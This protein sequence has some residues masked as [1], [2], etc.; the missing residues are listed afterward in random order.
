MRQLPYMHIKVIEHLIRLTINYQE[1]L[2]AVMPKVNLIL[3]EQPL[4]C[5][6]WIRSIAPSLLPSL[7][8]G[9]TGWVYS[10]TTSS[11]NEPGS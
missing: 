7:H 5:G 10:C 6:F 9:G 4:G 1:I 3:G 11:S 2:P 8:V